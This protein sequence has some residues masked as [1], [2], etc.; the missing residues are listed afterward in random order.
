MRNSPVSLGV[1]GTLA[2]LAGVADLP[3]VADGRFVEESL[4]VRYADLNLDKEA[5]VANLYTRLRNAAEQVCDSHYGPSPLFLSSSQRACV[6][7]ALEQ[8][9]ANVDRPALTAY[10]A[11]RSTSQAGVRGP[12]LAAARN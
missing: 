4:E 8:A 5:G 1:L 7:A 10:H 11:A 2:I 9:V 6:T 12:R 3:A